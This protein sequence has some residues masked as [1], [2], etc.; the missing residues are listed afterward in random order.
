M[1]AKVRSGGGSGEEDFQPFLSCL[2]RLGLRLVSQDT[3]NKM[4]VVWVLRRD[5]GEEGKVGQRGSKR[6]PPWPV[7]RACVYKK[8]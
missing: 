4:F 5:G 8:R 6:R 2:E 7:L 1:K 3:G